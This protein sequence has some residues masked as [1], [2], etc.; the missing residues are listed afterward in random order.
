MTSRLG[1]LESVDTCTSKFLEYIGGMMTCPV[2]GSVAVPESLDL[3]IILILLVIV[4]VDWPCNRN[5][6]Q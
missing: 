1:I 6:Y 5:G 3:N 2:K 4:K